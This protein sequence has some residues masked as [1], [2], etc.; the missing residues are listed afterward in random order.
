MASTQQ[1][2][3]PSPCPVCHQADQ[4]K[5]LPAAYESG[6]ERFAPPPMPVAKVGMSKYIIVGFG[7]VLVGSF[8]ILTWAGMG[9]YGTWHQALQVT[10]VV[11]VLAGIVTTLVLS[12]V[13]FQRVLKGDLQSQQYLPAW[14]QAMENW[15][16]LSYCKRDDVVFDPQTNKTLSD[17]AVKSLL[18]LSAPAEVPAP[19]HHAQA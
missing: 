8:I 16:R 1:R 15:R 18:S 13:A 19:A 2:V 3:P 4:V 12:W 17:A 14:D 9:G 7:L 5:S 6:V 10:L 11:L